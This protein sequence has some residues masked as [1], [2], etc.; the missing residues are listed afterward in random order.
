M[1]KRNTGTGGLS[2]SST[3]AGS[4]KSEP[5]KAGPVAGTYYGNSDACDTDRFNKDGQ[6]GGG[7]TRK[8]K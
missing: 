2:R 6:H 3:P 8:G 4:A 7:E 1:S 5:K